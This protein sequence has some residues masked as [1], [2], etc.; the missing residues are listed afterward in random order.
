VYQRANRSVRRLGQYGHLI[1]GNIDVECG[2]TF[3]LWHQTGTRHRM[4]LGVAELGYRFRGRDT[5]RYEV[6]LIAGLTRLDIIHWGFKRYQCHRYARLLFLPG[7]R[8]LF[9]CRDCHHLRYISQDKLDKIS[10][11]VGDGWN[12]EDRLLG[13]P[14]PRFWERW[15]AV[16]V[17]SI[18]W[19]YRAGLT[20][21][22]LRRSRLPEIPPALVMG[23]KESGRERPGRPCDGS[24]CPAPWPRPSFR[25][26]GRGSAHRHRSGPG[27]RRGRMP[28]RPGWSRRVRRGSNSS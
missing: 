16:A 13:I 22:R 15:P 24:R 4:E 20:S 23:S 26:T 6:T 25:G 9:L 19:R 3:P 27:H 14:S 2:D 12:R 8:R 5:I 21:R 18:A 10:R 28:R 1:V 7:S 17:P 11:G